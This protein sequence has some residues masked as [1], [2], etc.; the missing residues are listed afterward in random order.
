MGPA[1]EREGSPSGGTT[2]MNTLHDRF[3]AS[4]ARGVRVGPGLRHWHELLEEWCLILER[5][6]VLVEGDSI[7]WN[8]GRSNVAAVAAAAWGSGWAALEE[9]V[10]ERGADEETRRGRADLYLWSQCGEDYVEAKLVWL[11]Y[12]YTQAN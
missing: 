6:C 8:T 11:R 5:Y 10:N 9:F 3:P 2:R 12:G 4:P 1:A 7:Y